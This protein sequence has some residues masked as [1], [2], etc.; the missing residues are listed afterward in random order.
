MKGTPQ[1]LPIK[2]DLFS[3]VTFRSPEHLKLEDRNTR[4]VIDNNFT[5]S[6]TATALI[7]SNN[8]KS[9]ETFESKVA[10]LSSNRSYQEVRNNKPLFTILLTRFLKI[11]ILSKK[12]TTYLLKL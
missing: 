8:K 10:S 11:K 9:T 6:K 4:F 5:E 7:N 2:S 1:K 3:F 12:F